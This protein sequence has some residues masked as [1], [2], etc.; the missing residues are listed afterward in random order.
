[1]AMCTHG[2]HT[3]WTS[4]QIQPGSYCTQESH[5]PRRVERA[6]GTGLGPQDTE[7]RRRRLG[8]GSWA[9]IGDWKVPTSRPAA[10]AGGPRPQARRRKRLGEGEK[11]LPLG[12]RLDRAPPPNPGQSGSSPVM[13][14]PGQGF[15]DQ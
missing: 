10:G 9:A 13:S 5:Q 6:G 12:T 2:N 7:L 1:M 8:Q 14:H 4:R 11:R 15:W 3:P